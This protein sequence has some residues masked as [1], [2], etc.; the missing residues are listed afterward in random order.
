MRARI[1]KLIAKNMYFQCE[2][3]DTTIKRGP[4]Y[5]YQ[6][7]SFIIGYTPRHFKSICKKCI[8]R[9]VFGSKNASKNMKAGTLDEIT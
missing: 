2:M 6:G 4:K 1:S 8:Y 3:C 7:H 9:E 5:E